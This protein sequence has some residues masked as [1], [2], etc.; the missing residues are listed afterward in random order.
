MQNNS[1]PS[2]NVI[3]SGWQ[4]CDNKGRVVEKFEPFFATGWAYA[5]PRD[6]ADPAQ[7]DFGVKVTMFYDSRGRMFRTVNPDG[8]EQRVVYGVPQSLDDPTDP[9]QIV[10]TPWE[11]FTY[12]TNDNAGRTHPG[13]SGDYR[14]HWNTPA[15]SVSDA[16]GRT[17][18]A[19]VRNR[20]K[21][22]SA[23]APLPTIDAY[24]TRSTY[25]IQGNVLQVRDALNRVAF[26]HSYD[27]TKHALRIESIDAGTRSIVFDAMG[28]EIERADS[29]GARVLGSYDVLGRPDRTWARNDGNQAMTLRQHTFYGDGGDANQPAPTRDQARAGNSLS[30]VTRQLDEAGELSF[31][32][33]DFKGNVSEKARRVIADAPLIAALDA[34]GGPA[35]GF[36]VDWDQPPALS[37]NYQTSY[38]YDALNRL[39][40]LQY[41]ADV[42]GARKKLVPSYN[43]AGEL[44]SVRIDGDV[45]VERIVYNAK[46]QRV[47]I[48][49]GNRLMTRYAYDPTTL[50]LARLRTDSYVGG[51][52]I[53]A[54][55]GVPLQD[56]AYEYDL[57]GNVLRVTEQTPG[58]GV[59]N[60][61][62]ATLYPQLQAQL[63]AGDALVRDFEYDP[64]YRLTLATGREANNISM[65]RRPWG[66]LP[67][68]GFNWGA[69]GTPTPD[70]A[71]DQTRLYQETYSYDAAGNML[72]VGHGTWTR[73]FGISDFSPQAWAQ[74]WPKHLDPTNAWAAAT[75]NRLTHVGARTSAAPTYFFDADGNLVRE[76]TERHFAWDALD[77]MMAFA[78]RASGGNATIEA[79][80]LYDPAGQ[81]TKKL[82]RKGASVEVAV[83]V[84]GL[85]EH[86]IVGAQE[87]NSLHV[88]DGK[89]RLALIRVGA[90]LQGDTG[91]DIQYHLGDRL[92]SS[93]IVVGG[94]DSKASAFS[95]REEFF[96]YGDTSFGSYARK[97]YRFTGKE[98]DE[99]S[100]LNYHGY[101]Y[102]VPSILRWSSC[103]HYG[104]RNEP[105]M[106]VYVRNSPINL[107]DSTGLYA[108]PGHYYSTYIAALMAGF[109]PDVA[110]R[111]AFFTQMPDQVVQLDARAAGEAWVFADAVHHKQEKSD[112]WSHLQIV[113]RGGHSLTGANVS[114]ER[115]RREATLTSLTPGT[116]A[117]GLASHA[118][119]DAYA[120]EK[121]N[122]NFLFSP[123]LGHAPDESIDAIARRPEL[124]EQSFRQLLRIYQKQSPSGKAT[125]SQAEI[126]KFV[127]EVKS[128][129][130]DGPGGDQKAEIAVMEKWGQKLAGLLYQ[131]YAPENEGKTSWESFRASHP[132]ETENL[133]LSDLLGLYQKWM[134]QTEPMP[135]TTSPTM[136]RVND[137]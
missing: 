120:H 26:V 106:Y 54:P 64:L 117:H 131:R 103:D 41:P 52:L 122:T 40:T 30:R 121:P 88:M 95:N 93:H 13:T 101:R 66:D 128:A 43:N 49:Y 18:I 58:C 24:H 6:S 118:Y 68:D 19:T 79:C 57:A 109:A 31:T 96:P 22:A 75:S 94:S 73:Y 81:R 114:T 12:D 119:E 69:P 84:D 127:E 46:G 28:R 63:A 55:K 80:Y 134:D 65:N 102:Y 126:D 29:K 61:A 14:H 74:E 47:H 123:P 62:Q 60:N 51:G 108:Q 33:Y 23:A 124:W 59:R 98:R 27:L 87:N 111:T 10:P 5:P 21:P 42:S 39:T 38:A 112:I 82:V 8:S 53:Y 92:G 3:V 110:Y 78:N 99:E 107:V 89:S 86:H 70:T 15:S 100:G 16:L 45:F 104:K 37:G 125:V 137:K 83:Y 135:N 17:I 113:E 85:F 50:R 90:A 67:R 130:A 91:P 136:P 11:T 34:P 2:P 25:D 56:F 116:V 48:A 32:A 115:E 71:R 129:H 7:R 77:R 76:N 72:A 35:R 132:R 36:T 20:A 4:R 1:T 44:E 9:D 97:R 133:Q 105:N